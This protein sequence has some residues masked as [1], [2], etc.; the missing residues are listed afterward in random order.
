[1]NYIKCLVITIVHLLCCFKII[2]NK[3]NDELNG[4]DS[5]IKCL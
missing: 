1:M 3:I 2:L 5:Y 4:P